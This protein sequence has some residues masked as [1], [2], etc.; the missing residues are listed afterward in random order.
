VAAAAGDAAHSAAAMSSAAGGAVLVDLDMGPPPR[1][2]RRA[3]GG[4]RKLGGQRGEVL[5]E[6]SK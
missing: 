4:S 1:L 5:K 3:I 6:G 2:V